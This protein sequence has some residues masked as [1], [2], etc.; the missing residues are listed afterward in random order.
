MILWEIYKIGLLDGR[1]GNSYSIPKF[2][3]SFFYFRNLAVNVQGGPNW[4]GNYVD[5]PIIV[6]NTSDEFY[7]QPMYY[8]IGTVECQFLNF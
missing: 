6:S 2:Y 8:A 7:K 1:I 4:V 3:I 5:A